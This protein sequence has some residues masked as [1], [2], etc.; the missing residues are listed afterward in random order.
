MNRKIHVPFCRAV[1]EATP[2][3]TL[4]GALVIPVNPQYTSQL[5]PYK[6]EFVFT[7]CSI[8]EFWDEELKLLIDRD[9]SAGINIK[10]VGLGL[11]PTLSR[12]KGKIV[13]TNSVT[14]STL[15]KVLSVLRGLEKPTS[16]PLGQRG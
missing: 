14:N 12:R 10:R 4:I 2:S 9:I 1:E 13:I 15:K 5:L 3:L 11:F 6:D 8:R 16:V 7:D